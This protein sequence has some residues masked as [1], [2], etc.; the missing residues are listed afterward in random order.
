M[1][2]FFSHLPALVEAIGLRDLAGEREHHRDGVLGGGDGVAEGRV[3]HHD[4]ARGGG[5]DVDV[6]DADAGAADDLEPR[7]GVQHRAVT[8]VERC[9]WRGRHTRR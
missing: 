2:R 6:V 1:K 5:G 9:G 4:A 8:L 7:R 3:H